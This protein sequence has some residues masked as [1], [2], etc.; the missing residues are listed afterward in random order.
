[1]PIASLDHINI[2]TSLFHETASFYEDVLGLSRVVAAMATGREQNIWLA[3][4]DAAVIHLNGVG[5]DE[6]PAS[7]PCDSRIDHFALRADDIASFRE[8]FERRDIPYQERKLSGRPLRQLVIHDPNGLKV[9][10]VFDDE[11]ERSIS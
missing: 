4:G 3:V 9:E 8:L 11:E 5:E 10:L 1:M 7:N 6:D 2:R